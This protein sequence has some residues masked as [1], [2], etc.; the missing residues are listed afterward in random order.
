MQ[1][2]LKSL[3]FFI[4]LDNS[5]LFPINNGLTT[6]QGFFQ[7]KYCLEWSSPH[8]VFRTLLVKPHNAR[9]G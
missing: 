9:S 7:Q 4:Q 5:T 2:Y 8:T 6:Q 3:N 1:L